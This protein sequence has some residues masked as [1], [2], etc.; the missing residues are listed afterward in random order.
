MLYR[1]VSPGRPWPARA[2]G[3]GSSGP[4]HSRQPRP[5]SRTGP[6]PARTVCTLNIF[7]A[8]SRYFPAPVVDV[9][10]RVSEARAVVVEG[11]DGGVV[12]G[13]ERGAAG[14]GGVVPP[15]EGEAVHVQL[16]GPGLVAEVTNNFDI[17]KY[18]LRC[19]LPVS[20]PLP[21]LSP[22][23]RPVSSVS[24]LGKVLSPTF[25]RPGES[26]E[27]AFQSILELCICNR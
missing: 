18:F 10:G 24:R 13:V 20:A 26:A 22:A 11:V 2:G 1:D 5:G 8:V 27:C 23:K 16:P 17:Q 15:Q 7:G 4:R 25:T 21:S 14:L 9:R 12:L 19:Y 3:G 6:S